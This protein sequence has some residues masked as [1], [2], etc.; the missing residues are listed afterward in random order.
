MFWTATARRADIVFPVTSP[1]ERDDLMMNRRDPELIFMEKL[2]E[3]FGASRDDHDVFCGLAERLGTL[4]AFSGGRSKEAWLRALWSE[5]ASVGG[6]ERVLSAELRRISTHRPIRLPDVGR[7]AHPVRRFRR[8][9]RSAAI[10]D[11]KRQDR[12]RQRRRRFVRPRRL[13]RPSDWLEPAEWLGAAD[14]GDRLHLVSGQPLTRLHS[15]LD[16]GP[17]VAGQQ[18]PRPRTGVPAPANGA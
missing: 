4:A 7:D 5:A 3:P 11:A 6:K 12:A 9:S 2:A 16:N 18:G 1:L 17:V 14:L 15:Q 8:R 10:E 13:P